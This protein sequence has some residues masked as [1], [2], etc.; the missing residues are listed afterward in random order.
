MTTY[1]QLRKIIKLKINNYVDYLV[2]FEE[3]GSEKPHSIMF[4]LGLKKANCLPSEAIMVGDSR[5]K[6]IA[7]AKSS[8]IKTVWITKSK[9]LPT[10]KGFK[11]PD[12]IIR[13]IP[14]VLKIVDDLNN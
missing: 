4:L 5:N 2:T 1:V 6:D 3:T 7:G 12:K 14:E 8:G 9:T 13:S 11:K 10:E